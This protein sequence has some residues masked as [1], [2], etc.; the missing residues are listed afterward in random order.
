MPMPSSA[1][2][3]CIVISKHPR[4]H[5]ACIVIEML[6]LIYQVY[7]QNVTSEPIM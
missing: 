4:I 7:L 5:V 6:S 3:S 1:L 2:K